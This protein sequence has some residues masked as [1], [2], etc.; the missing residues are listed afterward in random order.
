[1]NIGPQSGGFLPIL[2][3]KSRIHSSK[4]QKRNR[5][6]TARSLDSMTKSAG[7]ISTANTASLLDLTT[8]TASAAIPETKHR[9]SGVR[10]QRENSLPLNLSLQISPTSTIQMPTAA[11]SPAI[12]PVL[13]YSHDKSGIE[14][15]LS[16]LD[17]LESPWSSAE[18]MK[19]NQN[20]GPELYTK[21]PT[22][23]NTESDARKPHPP[24][25]HSA[26]DNVPKCN[27]ADRNS[28]S[29]VTQQEL[30]TYKKPPLAP[31]QNNL[32]WKLDVTL[33]NNL[34][35]TEPR[36][37]EPA[38][39]EK[40][41]NDSKTAKDLNNN[42]ATDAIIDSVKEHNSGPKSILKPKS[43]FDTLDNQ[44]KKSVGI[45]T[46]VLTPPV[47]PPAR[48]SLANTN[49]ANKKRI[50]RTRSAVH[51]ASQANPVDS[52]LP[53]SPDSIDNGTGE[54]SPADSGTADL[55]KSVRFADQPNNIKEY[56][57]WEA[58]QHSFL[59]HARPAMGKS[60]TFIL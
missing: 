42:N 37:S 12:P 1:M 23:Q 44:N 2:K 55:I 47:P 15:V 5:S 9:S 29:K 21:K 45:S 6:A 41:A 58:P 24:P 59:N 20:S 18:D 43:D 35:T 56:L 46:Y 25:R 28:E 57:P 54:S 17:A 22:N 40:S 36:N 31:E 34:S 32:K 16:K 39:D 3:V 33:P 8:L 38:T 50:L 14:N 10:L 49:G 26:A 51:S 7:K 11:P 52:S 19:E 53:S 30:V 60:H 4:Q 13:K 27:Y 48:Q